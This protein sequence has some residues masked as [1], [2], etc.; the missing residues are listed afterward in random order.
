VI[1]ESLTADGPL[2]PLRDMSSFSKIRRFNQ[3]QKIT[4]KDKRITLTFED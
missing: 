4:G 3:K 1:A 2:L